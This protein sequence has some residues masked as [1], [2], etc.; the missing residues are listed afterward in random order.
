MTRLNL[1]T[2]TS[3]YAGSPSREGVAGDGVDEG[4]VAVA[5]E[6]EPCASASATSAAMMRPPGPVPEI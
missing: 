5:R 3:V 6:A 4:S 2:S 1:L